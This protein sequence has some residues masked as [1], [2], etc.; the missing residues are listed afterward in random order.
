[1]GILWEGRKDSF[2]LWW[3]RTTFFIIPHWYPK[4][5]AQKILIWR[6]VWNFNGWNLWYANFWKQNSQPG[7]RRFIIWIFW[8]LWKWNIFFEEEWNY[9]EEI[10]IVWY[11]NCWTLNSQLLDAGFPSQDEVLW[12]LFYVS[13]KIEVCTYMHRGYGCRS[14][15]IP[16]SHW[17]VRYHAYE[18]RLTI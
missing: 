11:M 7:L 6:I 1:M 9:L 8:V 17:P 16:K 14:A 13:G 10:I 2:V 18:Y 3:P 12:L 15:C 4:G 5:S